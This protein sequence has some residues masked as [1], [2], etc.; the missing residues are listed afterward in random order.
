[1]YTHMYSVHVE[2]SPL[3]DMY[4]YMYVY[5]CLQWYVC[6]HT[7]H[8]CTCICTSMYMLHSFVLNGLSEP[9][10]SHSSGGVVVVVKP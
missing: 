3:A 8:T 4:M 9:E 1:M 2:H 7:M 6:V 5:M 10:L